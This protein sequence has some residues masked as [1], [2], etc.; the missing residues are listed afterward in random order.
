MPATL[1][2][3]RNL[4]R[5]VVVAGVW[6]VAASAVAI[7]ALLDDGDQDSRNDTRAA[8]PGQLSRVQKDLDDR[9]DKLE[10]QVEDLPASEDVSKL[11]NRLKEVESGASGTSD[12]IKGLNGKVDDL[13]QRVE[14]AEQQ[15][16][17]S[18]TTPTDTAPESP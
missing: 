1:G 7:I 15:Q 6:A 16:S 5:W 4:R 8:T 9:I 10:S 2:E 17:R 14:E 11:E 18:E 3:L 13:E 12:D